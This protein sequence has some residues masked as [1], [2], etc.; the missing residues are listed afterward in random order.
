MFEIKDAYMINRNTAETCH[1]LIIQTDLQSQPFFRYYHATLTEVSN[2]QERGK[3]KKKQ[4]I[5]VY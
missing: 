4:C 2:P 1:C 3:I 5:K